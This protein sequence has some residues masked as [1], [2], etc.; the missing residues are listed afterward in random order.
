MDAQVIVVQGTPEQTANCILSLYYDYL[1]QGK[2]VEI[3]STKQ[4][5]FRYRGLP[6][7]EIGDRDHPES[8]CMH[9]FSSLREVGTACDIILTE[10]IKTDQAGLAYMNRLLR[11]A[12]FSTVDAANYTKRD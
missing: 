2:T 9:L 7:T 4:T 3:L 8:L 1:E 12:G 11:A 10:G 6:A 5:A